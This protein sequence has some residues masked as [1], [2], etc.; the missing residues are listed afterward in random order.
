MGKPATFAILIAICALPASSFGQAAQSDEKLTAREMF[1]AA[2]PKPAPV[3]KP[4]PVTPAKS[5]QKSQPTSDATNAEP[6]GVHLA[7]SSSP[8]LGLRYTVMK[9]NGDPVSPEA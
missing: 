3:Q 5:Q 1:Y 4:H 6:N 8:Y 7:V 2:P 9:E